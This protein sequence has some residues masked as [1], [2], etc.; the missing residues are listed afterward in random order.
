MSWWT[1]PVVVI[2]ITQQEPQRYSSVAHSLCIQSAISQQSY[3][4]EAAG[5]GVEVEAIISIMS[6][7]KGRVQGNT[8]LLVSGSKTF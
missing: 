6:S 2:G 5:G 4:A 8:R 7:L 3:R 1:A